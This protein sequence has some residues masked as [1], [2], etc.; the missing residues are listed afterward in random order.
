MRLRWENPANYRWSREA[1]AD[2]HTGPRN[3]IK[4]IVFKRKMAWIFDLPK[5][6]PVKPWTWV[7]GPSRNLGS[8]PDEVIW[9]ISVWYKK[10]RSDSGEEGWGSGECVICPDNVVSSNQYGRSNKGAFRAK[11]VTNLQREWKSSIVNPLAP[12]KKL[13]YAQKFFFEQN[14]MN[15]KYFSDESNQMIEHNL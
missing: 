9:L 12:L 3:K 2:L 1:G 15:R 7:P 6:F 14:W 4:W 5:K 8:A 13:F 11:R 10:I